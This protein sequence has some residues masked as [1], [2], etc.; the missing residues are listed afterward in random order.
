ML[1]LT[2]SYVNS[3]CTSVASSYHGTIHNSKQAVVKLVK[4]YQRNGKYRFQDLCHKTFSTDFW[5]VLYVL[6]SKSQPGTYP[7]ARLS[8]VFW[9]H[10]INTYRNGKNLTTIL[11]CIHEA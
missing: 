8:S 9:E 1:S 3:Y 2:E 10:A 11:T 5:R 6:D 7:T 4:F